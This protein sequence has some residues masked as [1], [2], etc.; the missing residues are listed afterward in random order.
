M[1][2]WRSDEPTNLSGSSILESWWEKGKDFG[3][4]FNEMFATTPAGTKV[5]HNRLS[6]WPTKPWD[7][8]GGLVTL[9]GDAAH[10]MTFR[11]YL[12]TSKEPDQAISCR[13]LANVHL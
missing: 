7:S 6:Y 1:Q 12:P 5:W 4:P 3:Y 13:R 2:T 9:V 11:M 10:P 8:H